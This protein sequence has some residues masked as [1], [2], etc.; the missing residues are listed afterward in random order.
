MTY[1]EKLEKMAKTIS[2][3]TE[4]EMKN[5]GGLIFISFDHQAWEYFIKE[6]NLRYGHYHGGDIP[7]NQVGLEFH[8]IQF[9]CA[10]KIN[11]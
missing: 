10:E 4:E 7:R 2:E 1:I 9:N 6:F 5:Q 3:V 11:Y 8:G